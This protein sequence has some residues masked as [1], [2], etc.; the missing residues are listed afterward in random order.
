METYLPIPCAPLYEVSN[1]GNVRSFARPGPSVKINPRWLSSGKRGG[2][3]LAFNT[4]F[5]YSGIRVL[6]TIKVHQIVALL[7]IGPVPQDRP[8]VMHLDEDKANN[9]WD[10]LQYGTILENVQRF[11]AHMKSKG[12]IRRGFNQ[13]WWHSETGLYVP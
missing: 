11:E 4:S 12:Y 8:I 2:I 9:R 5:T 6:T 7:F 3:Y 13:G 10:N 1:L